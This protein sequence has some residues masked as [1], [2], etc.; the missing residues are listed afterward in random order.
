MLL[1]EVGESPFHYLES[2][3]ESHAGENLRI[4]VPLLLT[5]VSQPDISLVTDVAASTQLKAIVLI[6]APF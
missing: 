2:L 4:M 5:L 6:L 1:T 3:D